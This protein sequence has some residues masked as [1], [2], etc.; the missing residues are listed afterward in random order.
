MGG[1]DVLYFGREGTGKQPTRK[2]SP[3][4]K[5]RG[6]RG[7]GGRLVSYVPLSAEKGRSSDMVM[8]ESPML[9]ASVGPQTTGDY[10]SGVTGGAVAGR[11]KPTPTRGR[12][13]VI[14][15]VVRDLRRPP[16]MSYRTNTG[17]RAYQG[18]GERS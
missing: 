2:P 13:C 12:E 1:S 15:G 14:R 17:F 11:K 10:Q 4:R 3:P 9:S 18:A 16:Q 8:R 6:E 5:E 7:G